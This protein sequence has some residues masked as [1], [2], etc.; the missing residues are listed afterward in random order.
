M[1]L[2]E[3]KKG[4]P[5]AL[6]P[7]L[8]P[9]ATPP[10]F[11]PKLTMKQ[12]AYLQNRVNAKELG[13]RAGARIGNARAIDRTAKKLRTVADPYSGIAGGG[14]SDLKDTSR[15]LREFSAEDIKLGRRNR[16]M[17]RTLL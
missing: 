15:M 4:L 3:I 16:D 8:R 13:D 1:D 5:S 10:V 17:S 12:A 7:A 2:V 9:E 11:N 14:A 6:R